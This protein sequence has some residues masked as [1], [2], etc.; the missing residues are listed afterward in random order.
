MVAPGRVDHGDPCSA[1]AATSM[2]SRPAPQRPTTTRSGNSSSVAAVIRPRPRVRIARTRPAAG[3]RR[4]TAVGHQADLVARFEQR[5]GVGVDALEQD[6]HASAAREHLV[7]EDLGS[8][9]WSASQAISTRL[10]CGSRTNICMTPL[11]SRFAW[12]HVAVS[13]DPCRLRPPEDAVEVGDPQAEVGPLRRGV[14]ELVEVDLL[15][16]VDGDELRRESEIG[17]RRQAEAEDVG[18]ERRRRR[19]DRSTIRLTCWML[20]SAIVSLTSRR[21]VNSSMNS[22]RRRDAEP[23]PVGAATR[24]FDDGDRLLDQVVEQRVGAQRVLDHGRRRAGKGEAAP[25]R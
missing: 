4:S 23:G 15:I 19:R 5:Q 20:L 9:G 6:D 16:V 8:T 10:P 21:T 14:G 22:G 24:P 11:A 3:R 1:A 18:V 12:P 2:L 17:R 7:V 13:I 25:R